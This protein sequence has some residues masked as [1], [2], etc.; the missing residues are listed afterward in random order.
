[1]TLDDRLRRV[2]YHLT[3]RT[4]GDGSKVWFVVAD[5]PYGTKGYHCKT[6]AEVRQL[7]QALTE[8]HL[9]WRGYE[10]RRRLAL[11]RDR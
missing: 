9:A 7:C 8:C 11:P 10:L 6:L 3:R 1:M 4:L 5:T 2:G